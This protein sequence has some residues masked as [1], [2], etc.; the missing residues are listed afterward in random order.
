MNNTHELKRP[1]H[2]NNQFNEVAGIVRGFIVAAFFAIVMF[3]VVLSATAATM[4]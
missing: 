4:I 2:M 1:T 3:P